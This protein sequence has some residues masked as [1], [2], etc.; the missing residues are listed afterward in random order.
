MLAV[1]VGPFIQ[2]RIARRQIAAQVGMATNQIKATVLSNNRQQWINTLR[3]TAAE[4][5]SVIVSIMGMRIVKADPAEIKIFISKTERIQ[6]LISKTRLLINP[7]EDD[8]KQLVNLMNAV[9]DAL[10]KKDISTMSGKS[11]K[12]ISIT[13]K[14]LKD[15]WSRVKNLQ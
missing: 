7:T 12:V 9:V 4:F 15:E 6:Y 8:H 3:D 11:E 1:F 14:I 13:Q 10:H 5:S 2:S